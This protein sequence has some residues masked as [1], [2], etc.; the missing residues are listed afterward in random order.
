[1][2]ETSSQEPQSGFESRIP[3]M[4][5]ACVLWTFNWSNSP[6]LL[7][8][9]IRYSSAA[10]YQSSIKDADAWPENMGPNPFEGRDHPRSKFQSLGHGP[11]WGV[12]RHEAVGESWVESLSHPHANVSVRYDKRFLDGHD[13]ASQDSQMKLVDGSGHVLLTLPRCSFAARWVDDVNLD[14]GLGLL[15]MRWEPQLDSDYE[16]PIPV[17]V[18]LWRAR[19][20]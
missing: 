16:T 3:L 2:S 17:R 10:K 9:R 5:P 11:A 4:Q 12:D 14:Q 20:A 1:M 19:L 15:V 6:L 18:E 13:K 8:L 7:W